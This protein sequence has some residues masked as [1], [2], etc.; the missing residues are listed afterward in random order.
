MKKIKKVIASVVITILAFSIVGC[1]MIERTPESIQKTVLATVEKEKITQGDLDKDLKSITESLK[2]KY[3]NDYAQNADIKDK[4][5]QLKQQY[6]TA[7]V[8]EKIILNRA[9]ALSLEPDEDTLNK[10]VDTAIQYYKDGYQTDEQYNAFLEQNGFTA[11]S[12]K[13]YQKNQAIVKYVQQDIV[14]D[15]EVTDADIKSYYDENQANYKQGAGA[16]VS[17]ILVADEATA[18]DVKSQLDKGADFASLAAQVSIDGTKAKGG[19]LGFIEYSSTK[20]VPEFMNGFKD[21]KEGQ[22]SEPV[23]SQFGYHIIKVTGVQLEDKVTPLD[24]VKEEIRSQLL[25]QKQGDAFNA[26]IEEWKK[27]IKVKVY[28]DKL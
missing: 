27:D 8:N 2:Q 7:I 12:F 1:K 25:Q 10:E 13:E 4:L 26:K 16:T 14:K 3:G 20:Y 21:L 22:I 9:E 5:K 28:E 11:D 18:K 24:Q 15:V 23:K 6:L 17:H 19:S